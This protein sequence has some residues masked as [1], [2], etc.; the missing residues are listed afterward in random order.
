MNS[1]K[2]A[3]LGGALALGLA[4][5]AAAQ[6]A[7]D[8]GKT[9]TPFGA[10][11]AANKDGSIPEW[12]GGITKPPAGYKPGEH[13]VD[14]FA[15]D[16]VLF[17]ITAKNMDQYADKLTEGQKA[18][19]K[20][21]PET[22]KI[23]VYPSHRSASA[24]QRIYDATIANA[25][26]AKLAAGGNGVEGAQEGIPF[27]I[28]KEGVE[29]VW[30]HVLRWRGVNVQRKVGQANP[31]ADGSYT[32]IT[33]D[34]RV[35]Y[36]YNQPGGNPG[37]NTS[38]YF[39][40]EVVAPAR[41]AG[42]IL[43]VHDTINQV[44][45]ARNAWTYN[46]GQ[47]RVR[48]APNVAYDN[49][50]TAADGL[51]TSDQLDMYNG[52]PD[53]YTWKLVGKKEMYVPYNSYKLH[54]NSL[55][56][57]DIVKPKH[58]NQDLARYELH[59]VWVVEGD[60]KPGTSH[61]YAKR[62]FYIDEDSWQILAADQYDGRGQMWRVGESHGI[63][64]YDVPVYTSTLDAIYDLQSGRY[65]AIGFDNQEPMYKFD[66]ELTAADFSPD[67]LRRAGVR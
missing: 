44:A 37:S 60:L 65:T 13:H 66:Q 23:N 3:L 26:R 51:R 8:L 47:R 31:Q 4:F 12:T 18:L 63:N 56:Y 33:I 36:L 5:P 32:M 42:E 62:R 43:L 15:G 6:S 2:A 40:Q 53:R 52:S 61:I 38:L 22:Y 25:S 45:E 16:K 11:K 27:P 28:P 50:G 19:L 39:L 64:Y 10:E 46:P 48:R 59:R 67:S 34:E 58:I 41:L 49:P 21:Y 54:S 55:K 9:L 35:K 57:D 29:A 20:T 7:S 30:N 1:F 24:P 14:P 17:T